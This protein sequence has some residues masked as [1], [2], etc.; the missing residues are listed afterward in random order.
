M[1]FRPPPFLRGIEKSMIR[2]ISD[3]ARPGSISLGLGEPDLPTP[4]VIVREAIRVLQEERNG[5]TLQAGLPELRERIAGDYPHMNLNLDQVV[6]TAG[7]QESLYLILRTLV[8]EGDEVLMPDPGFIA[9]PMITKITGG[10]DVRYRL[11]AKNDFGFDVEDFKN[12]ISNRTK[13]VICISPSNPTGRAL[14]NEELHAMADAVSASGSNAFIVSDEIYRELYYTSERPASISE[15]YPRTI[16]VSGLSKSMRMTGWR[17]G[18]LAGDEAVMKAALVLH[19]YVVTCASSISQKAALAAWTDEAARAREEYRAIFHRRR[20]HLLRLLRIELG[21]RCVTPDGAFY[22]MVDVSKYGDE[23]R[24][25]EAGLEHGVV[26]IPAAAF[27]DESK[28]YL[29]ISFCAEEERLTEGVRRL[30]EALNS[31]KH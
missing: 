15:F 22:T 13:V 31:I 16:I 2:K 6:V 18:W 1:T 21:L 30:G 17:I 8:E 23:L 12:K 14:T 11:P 4:E 7:S 20:D 24:V 9:Y 10:R 19:G 25:A 29:R 3:R 28:G 26:T 27:G 5:Y